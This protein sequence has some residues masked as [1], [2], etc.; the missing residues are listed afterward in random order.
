MKNLKNN[1]ANVYISTISF[2]SKA[3]SNC[4]KSSYY[5][6]FI[7][8]ISIELKGDLQPLLGSLGQFMFTKNNFFEFSNCKRHLFKLVS[9]PTK[10]NILSVS[11]CEPIMFKICQT[12]NPM[13]KTSLH[14]SPTILKG[15]VIFLTST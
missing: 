10:E 11:I 12:R 2:L 4:F 6:A 5:F 13:W 8:M 14:A 15:Q 7:S 1:N 9:I 3:L